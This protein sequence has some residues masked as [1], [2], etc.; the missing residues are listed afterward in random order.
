MFARLGQRD[1]HTLTSRAARTA[2]AVHIRFGIDRHIEVHHVRDVLHIESARRHVRGDQQICL[3]TTELLHHA[4][5]LIL[6]QPAVQ[7]IGAQ[8][9]RVQCF[10]EFIDFRPRATEDD[11]RRRLLEIEHTRQHVHLVGALHHVRYLTHASRFAVTDNL[12]I[13]RDCHRIA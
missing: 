5:T 6:A 2:D 10:G 9:A 13:D 7:R 12:A 8:S 1:R 11:R 3:A 4:I